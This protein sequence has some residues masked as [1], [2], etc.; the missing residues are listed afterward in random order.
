MD[1]IGHLKEQKEVHL[2]IYK[3][4][5]VRSKFPFGDGDRFGGLSAPDVYTIF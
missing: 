4:A 3:A 2:L 1:H 5:A